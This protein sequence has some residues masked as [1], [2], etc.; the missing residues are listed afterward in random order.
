MKDP[1]REFGAGAYQ[2]ASSRRAPESSA[3]KP[4]AQIILSGLP[5][6]RKLVMAIHGSPLRRSQ[7]L[8]P[9]SAAGSGDKLKFGHSLSV[10]GRCH[11]LQGHCQL[12]TVGRWK[13]ANT[14][15]ERLQQETCPSTEKTIM[16][17]S[18]HTKKRSQRTIYLDVPE[19]Y[20]VSPNH[21]LSLALDP[22]ETQAANRSRSRHQG[23]RVTCS[24]SGS[25]SMP[26]H[27]S[28]GLRIPP[29]HR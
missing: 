24:T 23:F 3:I 27:T 17:R 28:A 19:S 18:Q 12:R 20:R 22:P 1:C 7:S 13:R 25:A 15:T 21:A 16:K 26:A 9:H 2:S 11:T 4:T 6:D 29:V 8:K 14:I 10:A 5:V